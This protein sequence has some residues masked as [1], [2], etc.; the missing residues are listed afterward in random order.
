MQ[1]YAA[2]ENGKIR[3]GKCTYEAVIVPFTYSIDFSTAELL[4]TFMAAGGKVWLFDETPPCI[5]GAKADMSWLKSTCTK[6]DIFAFRD[7]VIRK[8]DGSSCSEIRK[9]VRMFEKEWNP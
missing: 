1:K 2:V 3:V 4:K 6:A 5:D 8:K 9:T 7:A